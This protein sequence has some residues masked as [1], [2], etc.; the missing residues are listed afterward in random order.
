MISR[1]YRFDYFNV[2][3]NPTHIQ[4][5]VTQLIKHMDLLSFLDSI[6]NRAHVFDVSIGVVG[7]SQSGKATLV[8]YLNQDRI[9]TLASSSFSSSFSS[10][11]FSSYYSNST[12]NNRLTKT[13]DPSYLFRSTEGLFQSK[14]EPVF[15]AF[16]SALKMNKG[17]ADQLSKQINVDIFLLTIDISTIQPHPGCHPHFYYRHMNR[18][19][20]WLESLY[21]LAP[22]IPVVIAGTHADYV[23]NSTYLE[24]WTALE[25][26]LQKGKNFHLKRYLN[27]NRHQ[28]CLLCNPSL[29]RKNA[30]KLFAKGRSTGGMLGCVDGSELSTNKNISVSASQSACNLQSTNNLSSATLLSLNSLDLYNKNTEA[31]SSSPQSAVSHSSSSITSF[32]SRYKFP[33]VLAYYE[34][35]AKKIVSKISKQKA[36]TPTCMPS[37][38]VECYTAEQLKRA[39]IKLTF[40]VGRG[41]KIP[42]NWS[43]FLIKL[44]SFASSLRLPFVS[45][46]DAK[47]IARLCDVPFNQLQRMLAYF[48]WKGKLVYFSSDAEDQLSRIVVV[49]LG[50]FFTRLNQ[51]N[52][53]LKGSL[54]SAGEI[55]NCLGDKAI[56]SILQQRKNFLNDQKKVKLK[57]TS[58]M[59]TLFHKG[60]LYQKWLLNA[61]IKL[62]TCLVLPDSLS[63]PNFLTKNP[64]CIFFNFSSKTS[65][66]FSIDNFKKPNDDS[67]QT[68]NE[69][70][71]LMIPLLEDGYPNHNVWPEQPEW[72]EK[73]VF[74]EFNIRLLK[75]GSF[76]DFLRRLNREGSIKFLFRSNCYF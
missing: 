64:Y 2:S 27:E 49:D 37:S 67:D 4:S 60:V 44:S 8:D 65:P 66:V 56:D 12:E 43:K 30:R 75:P 45:Y 55:I 40:E 20:M 15:S 3:L 18:L 7:E 32:G 62:E 51:L 36:S 19:Q 31:V 59:S 72:E 48:H 41:D 34:I 11:I 21:E 57:K 71:L 52:H 5:D 13:L 1:L 39:L 22:N 35:D 74:C 69:L 26:I 16:V 53:T 68:E 23:K 54:C 24:I 47:N 17:Y 14:Q 6:S 38:M 70:R 76:A 63:T 46:E 9:D 28:A 61:I 25:E 10:W 29:Q 33:H 58:Q 50:W 73:Q 42:K